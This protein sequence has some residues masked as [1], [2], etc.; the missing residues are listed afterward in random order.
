MYHKKSSVFCLLQKLHTHII[1]KTKIKKVDRINKI[2]GFFLFVVCEE[3]KKILKGELLFSV[4]IYCFL[5][6]FVLFIS[7]A[8]IRERDRTK[9]EYE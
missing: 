9:S 2:G 7:L 4:T 5:F 8:T 1:Y 3:R 6:C